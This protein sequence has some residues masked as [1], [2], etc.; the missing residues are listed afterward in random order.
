MS[1]KAKQ[2][3]ARQQERYRETQKQK[4]QAAK[5]KPV[6]VDLETVSVTFGG[7]PIG[8]YS[9]VLSTKEQIPSKLIEAIK[10]KMLE[11]MNM[12][13]PMEIP[14]LPV[15]G[16]SVD[17]VRFVNDDQQIEYQIERT[18]R[19]GGPAAVANA[20]RSLEKTVNDQN[21]F[22]QGLSESACMLGLVSAVTPSHLVV[23]L[24][25]LTVQAKRPTVSGRPDAIDVGDWV[26]VVQPSNQV[27][28]RCDAPRTGPVGNVSSINETDGTLEV[29]VSG[30]KRSVVRSAK[31]Q[32]ARV[33]DAV[34][35]DDSGA[36]ALAMAA[37]DA[38]AMQHDAPT[39]V[40]WDSIGGLEDAKEALREAIEYPLQHAA[41]W[42]AYG[43]KPAKGA[44]LWGPPG[45]GKTMLG[46][47]VASSLQA[48]GAPGGFLYVKGP[49]LL[50]KYVGATEEKIR[51]LFDRAR[52]YRAEHGRPA[53]IFIDEAEALL[54]ERRGRSLS[55]LEATTVPTFLAEMDGLEDHAAFV[56]LS[57]NLPDS[58]DPAVVRDGRIDRRIEVRRPDLP[59]AQA[60]LQLAI[61]G[62]PL[63]DGALRGVAIDMFDDAAIV[64][65]IGKA[66]GHSLFLRMRDVMSGAV[67]AGVV[68]RAI[69]HAMRRDR[70]AGCVEPSGVAASDFARAVR[71]SCEELAAT[72]H[73]HE[74]MGI[75]QAHVGHEKAREWADG[76]G[77]AG[78]RSIN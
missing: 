2:K 60:I 41:L 46:K 32:A 61:H 4:A 40:T 10:Q 15:Y 12:S 38:A 67:I 57:T 48:S 39:G 58:L 68:G 69:D 1:A 49:E 50:N 70:E 20:F 30:A 43:R 23:R 53:V 19:M 25:A 66:E 9:N 75:V 65:E 77:T 16:V 17:E 62:V 59:Q 26:R 28:G 35:I 33:G 44:L 11:A 78:S 34:V 13:I 74:C 7:D 5:S 56:L 76:A 18:Y 22:I 31:C 71:E 42:A 3:A 63:A 55:G 51:A 73:W 54:G 72:P 8:T 29:E 21:A 64:R 14:N 47:A 24:G 37:Q 52:R 27:L 6:A 45:C 36:F